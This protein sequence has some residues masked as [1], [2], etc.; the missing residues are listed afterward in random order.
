[1]FKFNVFIF[2]LIFVTANTLFTNLNFPIIQ[3][4]KSCS[5]KEKER[6][7]DLYT[8]AW[9]LYQ[10]TKNMF[11]THEEKQ[12]FSEKKI[13]FVTALD[14]IKCLKQIKQQKLLLTCTSIY[15][16]PS[17]KSTLQV[18]FPQWS[19]LY[20][21]PSLLVV[22]PLRITFLRLPLDREQTHLIIFLQK[23]PISSHLRNMFWVTIFDI[24][25][26]IM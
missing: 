3:I 9:D 15:Q 11:R 13:R 18:F 17:Y 4:W 12:V 26:Y 20:P 1:M 21:P 6:F 25:M 19:G 5:R 16:T 14:L 8:Y 22:G 10:V 7:D 2:K 23:R 24:C